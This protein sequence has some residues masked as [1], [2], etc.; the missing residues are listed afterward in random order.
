MYKR[1]ELAGSFNPFNAKEILIEIGFV[2]EIRNT[3]GNQEVFQTL[4]LSLFPLSAKVNWLRTIANLA[5]WTLWYQ[6]RMTL[7]KFLLQNIKDRIA[8]CRISNKMFNYR[9]LR[10][11][12]ARNFA[13]SFFS[14]VI[15]VQNVRLSIM[16]IT[17]SYIHVK[18]I[19]ADNENSETIKVWGTSLLSQVAL[20]FPLKPIS[21]IEASSQLR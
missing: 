19:F 18:S 3:W 4:Y 5:F 12:S 16:R 6:K 14:D 2:K 15:K 9:T 1:L 10:A 7:Q 13:K 20:I 11:Y 8:D 21:S 17:E